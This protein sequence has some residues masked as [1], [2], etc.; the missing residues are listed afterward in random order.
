MFDLKWNQNYSGKPFRTKF[1]NPNSITYSKLDSLNKSIQ[2][3]LFF[4]KFLD[5]S[6]YHSSLWFLQTTYWYELSD[7]FFEVSHSNY[8]YVNNVL[9]I[10]FLNV[11]LKYINL[12]VYILKY[13]FY[14]FALCSIYVMKRG[15]LESLPWEPSLVVSISFRK[16]LK[17]P[18]YMYF[19]LIFFYGRFYREI[20][21]MA[22]WPSA[23]QL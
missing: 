21:P 6:I 19:Y 4:K 16:L 7:A 20:I 2:E 3:I 11:Y 1:M 18:L 14:S 5:F 12:Y 13:M 22:C 15:H 10:C 23:V 9:R 8:S 17:N